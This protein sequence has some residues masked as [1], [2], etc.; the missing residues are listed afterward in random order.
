MVLI[1]LIAIG[2]DALSMNANQLL[3]VKWM[4]RNFTMQSAKEI[5]SQVIQMDD[6]KAIRDYL[7]AVM[8][9]RKLGDNSQ[10]Q[11]LYG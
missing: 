10:E 4:I 7:R 8:I 6:P 1:L 11:H 2:F 9:T 5:L 3:K